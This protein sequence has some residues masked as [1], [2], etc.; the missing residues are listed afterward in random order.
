[1]SPR[2]T[3]PDALARLGESRRRIVERLKRAGRAS[4]GELAE[5]VELNR[6]T[7][8]AHVRTLAGEGL[9]ERVGT[10]REGP[11][12]PEGL[13]ALTGAAEELFPR[14]EGE[15]LRGL[16]EHLRRSGE[17]ELLASY[18][19]AYVEERKARGTERLEGLEG[20]D[21]LEEVARILSEDGFMAE[22]VDGSGGRAGDGPRLRLGHCPLRELV[23]ATRIPC[24]AEIGLVRALLDADLSRVEYIPS[25][26]AACAYAV[27]GPPERGDDG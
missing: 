10:R 20:R 18:F 16:A 8:R 21:R 1:M 19:D 4:V 14:R 12:R 11:G 27:D 7:V 17:Q 5:A 6:E 2:S 22:V 23:H 24:R 25:G 15:V 9:V 3:P 26:D 13:Y